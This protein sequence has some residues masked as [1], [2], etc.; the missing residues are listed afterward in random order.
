MVVEASN[1]PIHLVT[2]EIENIK[3]TTPLD[4]AIAEKLLEPSRRAS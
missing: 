3:I 2:G 4:L 1:Q